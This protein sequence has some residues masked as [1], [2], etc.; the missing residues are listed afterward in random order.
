MLTK[1]GSKRPLTLSSLP[2]SATNRSSGMFIRKMQASAMSSLYRN[3]R[4]GVPVP[5]T[6]TVAP[7]RILASWN[8]R[9]KAGMTWLSVGW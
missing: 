5:Q 1:G 9:I 8:L 7:P 2:S 4:R 6:V 3:S